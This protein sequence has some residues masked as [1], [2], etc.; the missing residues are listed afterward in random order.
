V[1]R[2]GLKRG[3]RVVAVLLKGFAGLIKK[4]TA[5][6][7]WL[8]KEFVERVRFW[9]GIRGIFHT[10]EL[11]SYGIS[12]EEVV[13]LMDHLGAGDSDAIVFVVGPE[14]LA[15]DA[16]GRVV[17]RA[18][19]ALDGVPAET[20]GSR[21]DGKTFYMRPRPGMARMYPETDIPPIRITNELMRDVVHYPIKDPGKIVGELM[22]RFGISEDLAWKLYDN[23]YVGIFE[24]IMDRAEKIPASYV[25]SFLTDTLRYLER[26]GI[27]LDKIGEG[28]LLEAFSLVDRDVIEKESIQDIIKLCVDEGVSVQ[29]AIERLGLLKI[30]DITPIKKELLSIYNEREDIRGLPIELRKKRLMAII[31][32]KYRGKVDPKDI[33]K[34]IEEVVGDG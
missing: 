7:Y 20:R 12:K 16:I 5:P 24:L 14:R 6:G 15:Y 22:D 11:P 29:E 4:E 28:L 9:T 10:D 13:N 34:I 30:K 27:D 19:E 25:A 17:E 18:A 3:D 31:M 1:I 21:G 23:E 8:G 32:S 2:R 33:L 26:E